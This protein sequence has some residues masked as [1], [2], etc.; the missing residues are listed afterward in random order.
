MALELQGIANYAESLCALVRRVC[1]HN[2]TKLYTIYVQL[3]RKKR[4]VR[5]ALA[6]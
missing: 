3:G 4:P 1:A 2:A 6:E 5:Y